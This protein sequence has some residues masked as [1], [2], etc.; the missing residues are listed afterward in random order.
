MKVN[1]VSLLGV[2]HQEAVDALRSVQE[3]ISMVVCDGFDPALISTD[4]SSPTP[5]RN[6]RTSRLKLGSLS[7]IDRD[8]EENQIMTKVNAL[9]VDFICNYAHI[10]YIYSEAIDLASH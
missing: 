9:H 4:S 6:S 10:Q 7:S 1:G 2:S 8:S 5:V 3:Y